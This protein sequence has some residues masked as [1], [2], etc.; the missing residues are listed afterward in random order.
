M[1]KKTGLISLFLFLTVAAPLSAQPLLP[2]DGPLYGKESVPRIDILIH[3]DTLA[4]IY[5]NVESDHDFRAIFVFDNGNIHDTIHDIGFRLRGNTSRYSA[6]KSFK[7]SF[8]SFIKGRKYYG[9]EKL[10]LNGEH[11]DPSVSRAGLFW[12]ILNKASL[13]GSRYNHVQ[14]FINGYYY[15]LYIS[16][17]H[18][19]E[20][21]VKTY[22]GNNNGNLYKCLWPA[23][24]TYRGANPDLYKFKT[25]NRRTYEL[26]TN[27]ETDDYSDLANFIDI[28]NNTPDDQLPC[29]LESVFNVQ[30]YLKIAAIDIITGNWDDYIY[31][32]NNFYLYHNT[33]SGL[34][35]FIPY[36]ADNT[37]GIDWAGI[38]WENRNI[39]NWEH[40]SEPRPLFTRLMQIPVYKAQFTYYLKQVINEITSTQDFL[41]NLFIIRE[42]LRP[43]VAVDPFYPL[44]YGYT[45][46]SFNASFEE[47]AGAHVK[48]GL[49]PFLLE[50]NSTAL[51][52]AITGNA[53]PMIK[54]IRH[55]YPYEWQPIVIKAFAEDDGQ[56]SVR[57]EYRINGGD[58]QQ[59][60]M[61]EASVNG[62]LPG[63][64][65]NYTATLDG[66]PAGTLLEF[67]IKAID[68]LNVT[69][70]KPCNPV[71][72]IIPP[73]NTLG[74]FINEF[75][76]SNKKT[77]ADE[78]DEFDDWIEIFN[79]SAQSIWLGD[80]YLTDNLSKPTK[81]AFPD[82]SIGPGSYLLIWAD[83][84]PEQGA[85]HATFKLDKAR[86]EIGL[87]HNTASGMVLIDSVSYTAQI[88]DVSMGRITDGAV[89][90]KLFTTP[91]PGSTN[92]MLG[93][94]ENRL[95]R[96]KIHPNPNN[97]GQLRLD[98]ESSFSIFDLTGQEVLR[99]V[100][101]NEA[102]I[103][104]L[105]PGIYIVKTVDG[106]AGRLVVL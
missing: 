89:E 95:N 59:I 56:M 15:G 68:N 96:L 103:S 106:G 88:T 83:G 34:F 29:A 17:E 6:K 62:R 77:I 24:L 104:H 98:K 43:Y 20:E 69:V 76:A 2:D 38:A 40:P 9:V 3:P 97:T 74:L 44:D 90:W 70:A 42:N 61:T 84:Q 99:R 66:M 31:G 19:D 52:Q 60:A 1:I 27:R 18:I 91:T 28:L 50:R 47:A 8:N 51:Q 85:L 92:S 39:Y 75:M 94:P 81:W 53:A 63:H 78:Y 25:G 93:I 37:F 72:Y 87:F 64:N 55:N 79:G 54:Y 11:N 57:L 30:D 13:A 36:D 46:E 71:Q 35:E 80:K 105:K 7:V 45:I 82:I 4:W 16:V 67:R 86:E 22:F 49:L 100:K 102:D 26:K 101:S 23:D 73:Q 21:F 58:W 12:N 5:E 10:N 33:A 48:T 32:K 65:G 14:V 41:D